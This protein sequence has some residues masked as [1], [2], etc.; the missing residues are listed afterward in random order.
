MGQRAAC[1][2]ALDSPDAMQVLAALALPQTFH[3]YEI[4]EPRSEDL[5]R[6]FERAASVLPDAKTMRMFHL[7]SVMAATAIAERGFSTAFA[8]C[9]A[10]GRGV[11]LF[12]AASDVTC[13]HPMCSNADGAACI[14][15][16]DV[17][18]GLAH[19]NNSTQAWVSGRGGVRYT[20][21]ERM[22]PR[23]GFDALHTPD[24]SIWVIPSARRVL[25]R[26]F[27]FYRCDAI[28][29]KDDRH[30]RQPSRGDE[31]GGRIDIEK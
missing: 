25:P 22:R 4:L 27:V 29:A 1:R 11:N 28:E 14:V 19:E 17:A 6:R 7:T 18:V 30:L 24:G 3:P 26:Y 16:C 31:R 20:R 8:R 2:L 10:F 5:R 15:V 12:A 9:C 21:P 23:P 13:L